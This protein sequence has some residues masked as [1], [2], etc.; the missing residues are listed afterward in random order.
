MGRIKVVKRDGSLVPFSVDKIAK[1]IF[2]SAERAGGNNIELS[3][4]I[5]TELSEYILCVLEEQSVTRI[6]TSD[7]E[8]FVIDKLVNNG[9]SATVQE[10]IKYSDQRNRVRSMN[11]RFYKSIRDITFQS[12]AESSSKRENANIDTDTAMGTMLKYGSEAAKEFNSSEMIRPEYAEMHRSGD[13][14]IHD[15]DF[16]ALT[17]TCCQIGLDKLFKGGFNTGHGFLREPKEIGTAGALSAIAIQSNQND[18]H[19]S[20]AVK[21]T[22]CMRT[23]PMY[24][25]VCC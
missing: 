12:S 5:A 16:Y 8:K 15:L 11:S 1:S 7:I 18:Q 6:K 13:I 14:H 22:G 3:E 4:E 17:M 23:V 24:R 9:N 2:S 21:N 20:Y 19:K 10:Y 25:E